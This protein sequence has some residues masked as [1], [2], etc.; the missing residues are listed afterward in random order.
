[1]IVIFKC[2]RKQLNF[3]Q[4]LISILYSCKECVSIIIA[5]FFLTAFCLYSSQ[6]ETKVMEWRL[7]CL[8]F[9]PT[10]IMKTLW[11]KD[12]PYLSVHKE[13]AIIFQ[14]LD[15]FQVIIHKGSID[16]TADLS[17]S[18]LVL[19]IQVSKNLWN[20]SNSCFFGFGCFFFCFFFGYIK[21]SK[22]S[23]FK[24][25]WGHWLISYFSYLFLKTAAS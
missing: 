25:N 18:K 7:E 24:W 5:G 4:E 14:F 16:S 11:K 12:R 8:F 9:I 15:L 19:D 1:M 10:Y 23:S 17:D 3:S 22:T 21:L 20:A 2:N 6:N 13:M